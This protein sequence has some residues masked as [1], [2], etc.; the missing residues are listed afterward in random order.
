[1][2][3]SGALKLRI[4][5]Q[6][7][8]WARHPAGALVVDETCCRADTQACCKEPL[9]RGIAAGLTQFI[10]CKA[11]HT[12]HRPAQLQHTH[13]QKMLPVMQTA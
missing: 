11:N 5:G 3:A 9:A 12:P 1:M 4:D 13:D 10:F 2:T 8:W 7:R 6:S